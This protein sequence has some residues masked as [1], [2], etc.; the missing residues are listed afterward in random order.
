MC[1][2]RTCTQQFLDREWTWAATYSS[3]QS[4]AG[5]HRWS[6]RSDKTNNV[7]GTL[8]SRRPQS[9]KHLQ[10]NKESIFLIA[11]VDPQSSLVAAHTWHTYFILL[12]VISGDHRACCLLLLCSES[13]P[14]DQGHGSLN[15]KAR[16]I[17]HSVQSPPYLLYTPTPFSLLA[18]FLL[19]WGEKEEYSL[20]SPG[21]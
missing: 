3:I 2:G 18:H 1:T 13:L 17:R 11:I 10:A 14:V 8:F 15:H 12:N 19:H 9:E 6:W 5:Q 4:S 20:G 16:S 21:L 7:P